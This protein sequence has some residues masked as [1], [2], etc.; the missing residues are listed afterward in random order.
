MDGFTAHELDA[1]D[2]PAL[3]ALFDANPEYFQIINGRDALP[4]EAR[5]EFEDRPPAHLAYSRQHSLGFFDATDGLQGM[6]TVVSDLC[7]EGVWHVTLFWLATRWHGKGLSRPL[8]EALEAWCKSAG[9]QWLRL[10]A[11]VG[12]TRAERFW[13]SCGFVEVR[14]RH[15]VDTGGLIN[16]LRVMLKPMRGQSMDEYL[17]RVPRDRPGSTLP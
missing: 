2:I 16:D 6:A 14:R 9:A 7:A 10:G 13:E 12:N 8:Y 5:V 15:G 3:Q 11:V 1:A 17:D 4:G